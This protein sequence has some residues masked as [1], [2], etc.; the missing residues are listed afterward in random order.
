MITDG[1]DYP[2]A[3]WAYAITNFFLCRIPMMAYYSKNT[4]SYQGRYL[5]PEMTCISEALL[6]AE[7][8]IKKH[9]FFTLWHNF[10]TSINVDL[11]LPLF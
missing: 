9:F 5:Y 6:T 1:N 4:N 10:Q 3:Y 2:V 11:Y 8:N 7:R